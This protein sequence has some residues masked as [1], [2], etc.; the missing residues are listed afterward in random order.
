MTKEDNYWVLLQCGEDDS[1]IID[2]LPDG[3]PAEWKLKE[4]QKMLYQF[5]EV[6]VLEFYED[7]PDNI[8]LYDFVDNT[9][10]LLIVSE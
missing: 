4:S 5:P 2:Y 3:S 10:N 8:K 9:M 1:A 7:Y 6:V